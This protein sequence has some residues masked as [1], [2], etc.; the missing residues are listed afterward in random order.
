MIARIRYDCIVLDLDGTLICTSEQD[1]GMGYVLNFKDMHG[2]PTTCW[3]HLRPGFDNFIKKC[4]E[5][6]TVG[7]WSM[8]QPGYVEA[9]VSTF[10][11]IK[12]AFVYN[13]CHC[14]RKH[15]HIFKRLNNI[16]HIGPQILMIDDDHK[17]L[18]YC[19]RVTTYNITEWTPERHNDEELHNLLNLIS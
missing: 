18:E 15:S 19:D 9:V 8:G 2:D 16:P 4:F 17:K 1:E 3:V 14:D 10:F 5:V 13:W 7:V 6:S 12:P 11:P